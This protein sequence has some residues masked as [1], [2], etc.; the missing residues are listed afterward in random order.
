MSKSGLFG[1]FGG[2]EQLQLAA[3]EA[4]VAHFTREVWTPVAHEEPGRPRLVAVIDA[5]IA[6]HERGSLPGGCFLTTATVEFDARPGPLRD[7]VATH[8][9][10]WLTILEHDARIAAERGD[11]PPGSDPADI[12][13]ELNA[14][15]SAG[16]TGHHL[17][18]DTALARA[19]RLMRTSVGADR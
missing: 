10:R 16:S 9:R 14:L 1:L 18:R 3:L 13:F 8:M 17:H 7:A 2:R 11:L 6:Y 5:W 19:R 4:A 12:A 15:A